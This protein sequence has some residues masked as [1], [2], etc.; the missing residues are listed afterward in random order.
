MIDEE[1]K[2]LWQ[3]ANG[4]KPDGVLLHMV[5]DFTAELLSASKPAPCI[6]A[7]DPKACYRVRCQLGN[8]CVYDDMSPRAPAATAQSG[9]P[10][11]WREEAQRLFD[12]CKL[13]PEETGDGFMA[14]LELR[15]H[16]G[17]LLEN[18]ASAQSGEAV[19][20]RSVED[21]TVT[22]IPARIYLNLGDIYA[23]CESEISFQSLT[24]ITWCEDRIDDEDIEYVRAE[25][26]IGELFPYQ[27]TF[28]AIAAATSVSA[29]HVAIS[30]IKF[31]EA[32]GVTPQPHK[33]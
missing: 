17:A 33:P 6:H 18:A 22:N 4:A 31:R 10:V 11:A 7:N 19:A 28:D 29:G 20:A 27:K 21:L 2:L 5:R 9:E 26:L 15:N 30:V 13:W 16:V 12:R 25:G 23:E 1:I 32:F 24:D 14:L 8:K 3:K